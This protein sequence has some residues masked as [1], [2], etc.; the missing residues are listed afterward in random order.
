M[1]NCP[2]ASQKSACDLPAA[3]DRKTPTV[4][5]CQQCATVACL[6]P[7]GH[8][9]RAFARFCTQCGKKLRRPAAWEMAYA[10]PQ[11]TATLQMGEPTGP[12][13]LDSC[14]F[15]SGAAEIPK[16]ET[17]ES[18]PG[19]LAVD[20]L[21][22]VPN[23][24]AQ[25]LDAYTVAKHPEQRH[26]SRQWS[27][28]FNAPLTHGCTPVYHGLHLYYVVSGGIH[29]TS[30]LD[31]KSEP[32][33]IKG[34]DAAQIEP[35]PECAPLKCD[36]A[37]RQTMIAGLQQGVLLLELTSRDRDYVP[38]DFFNAENEPMSPTLCGESVVFTSK[39]GHIFAL[40]LGSK[41]YQAKSFKAQSFSAPIS[42]GGSVYFE[43]V[44][45]S[46]GRRSLARYE[47]RTKRLSQVATLDA[48]SNVAQ[49]LKLFV[50]PPLT[51]GRRLFLS[52]QSGQK[53]YTYHINIDGD[54]DLASESHLGSGN[55][56]QRFV[57]HR[58]IAVNNRIYSA[59]SSGLTLQELEPTYT[60]S[61]Q[62]LAMGMPDNPV[63]VAAPI[64]YG[65]KL[66]I[67]C[68]D[69][70]VCLNLLGD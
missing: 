57:P 19:L 16:I 64:Q 61:H 47:P 45:T 2:T 44:S 43:A 7:E 56:L 3:N 33:E 67:L 41:R 26:L 52:D 37:G 38:H 10:N 42:L 18:L 34:L 35:L 32:V 49:H 55:M 11:R 59:H 5:Y 6:C 65:D 58:S 54:I 46:N 66:F 24:E 29:K 12:Q 53:R 69:R 62:A 48:V 9:N 1:T 60:V 31:G 14:G 15:F 17:G 40:N 8:W 20:G 28:P 51:D 50:H 36:V 21:I 27:I 22:V 4:A 63:P 25:R 39:R 68:K 23:P 13:L 70:L 30:V